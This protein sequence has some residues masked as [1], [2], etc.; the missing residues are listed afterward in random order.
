MFVPVLHLGRGL[1]AHL[2]T[3]DKAGKA[4]LGQT[5][6]HIK[7]IRQLQVS[8]SSITLASVVNIIKL[9]FFVTDIPDK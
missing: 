2:K 6:W 3:L 7:P 1:W 5:I 8:K 4:V 9:F